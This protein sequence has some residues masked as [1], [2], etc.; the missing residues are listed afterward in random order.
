M[1]Y[2]ETSLGNSLID[3]DDICFLQDSYLGYLLAFHSGIILALK[4]YT[5]HGTVF[6]LLYIVICFE[7]SK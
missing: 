6:I 2:I 4:L 5:V 3:C 1:E 7:S